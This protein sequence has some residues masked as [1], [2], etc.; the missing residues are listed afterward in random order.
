MARDILRGDPTW[1]LAAMW[2][3]SVLQPKGL[4]DWPVA[5]NLY[6]DATPHSVAAIVPSMRTSVAQAFIHREEI[7]RAEALAAI[8]GYPGLAVRSS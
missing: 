8:L 7:N 3:L 6:T 2:D 5:V 1:L 4:R